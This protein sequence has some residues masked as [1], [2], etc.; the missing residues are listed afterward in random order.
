MDN[1]SNALHA[2]TPSLQAM[3]P[4]GLAVRA[5]GWHRAVVDQ[6]ATARTERFE[7]DVAGRRTRHWDA[8]LYADAEAAANLSDVH[9]LS[10]Q[11]LARVSVDSG[12]FVSLPGEAGQLVE[13]WNGR[14]IRRRVEY[15]S[16]LRPVAIFES[17]DHDEKCTERLT[18]GT[19][20]DAF[21]NQCGQLIR[22]DD[23]A[24][25]LGNLSFNL[26][27]EVVEQ[28]RRFLN[29]IDLPDWPLLIEERDE[30]LELGEGAK[31]TW[32]FGPFGDVLEQTDAKGNLQSFAQT[33]AGQLKVANLRLQGQAARTLVSDIQYD[34]QGR[35]SSEIAGNGVVTA[36]DYDPVDGRLIRLRA[37]D[38]HLQDLNYAYDPVGNVVS[39]EDRAQPTRHFANQRI[40]PLRTFAY[41]TLYQLIEATGYE[42]AAINHGPSDDRFQVFPATYELS[43][44][45]QRYEYDAGGNLQTLVH[46]GAQN[47]TRSL[48]LRG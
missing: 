25:S 36:L 7:F 1:P 27:G 32:R 34:A 2:R 3:D 14:V 13:A 39:I 38:G 28:T 18:Y 41:D 16:M 30:L 11:A 4:R 5:V 24:G 23:Q 43:N 20:S 9:S 40:E 47:H 29:D 17:E 15:D 26:T 6:G 48:A 33:I 19:T 31:S 22:H 44:Y 12:W 35:F 45:T 46:V 42:A 37:G 10:D 21:A 8:R